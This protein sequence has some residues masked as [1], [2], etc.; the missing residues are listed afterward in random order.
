M[1]AGRGPEWG[2]MEAWKE[3]QARDWAEYQAHL[4]EPAEWERAPGGAT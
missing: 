3:E 2:E 4:H 1:P